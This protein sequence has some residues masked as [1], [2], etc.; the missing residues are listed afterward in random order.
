[1]KYCVCGKISKGL[2]LGMPCFK[3]CQYAT[4]DEKNYKGLK[5]V[6]IKIAQRDSVSLG[7]KN[8]KMEDKNEIRHVRIHVYP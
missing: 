7:P 3:T 6:F 2:V 1:M 8:Q 5:Y 4:M